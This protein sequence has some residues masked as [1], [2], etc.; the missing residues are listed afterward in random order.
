MAEKDDVLQSKHE[1]LIVEDSLTQ[2]QN[3]KHLLES[4]QYRVKVAGDGRHALAIIGE[5]K[6]DLVITD[7]VM[8]EM[9][10]YELCR[11]IKDG[12][13]TRDIPVILLTSLTNPE[14]VLEGLSC[15][16]DNFITKP[17]N[18]EYLLLHVGQILANRRLIP[19]ERIR[20]EVEIVFGGKRRFITADQQQMISLLLSTYEAAAQ[21]NA[22]LIKTQE[23]LE[24][25]ND[26]LEEIVEERTSELQSERDFAET[27]VK[28]APAA[29]LLLNLQGKIIH[30][31]PY[32]EE[33]S[34]Y[35]LEEVHGQNWFTDF[36]PESDQKRVTDMFALAIKG[37]QIIGNIHSVVCK[38]GSKRDFEW[39]NKAIKDKDGQITGLLAIGQDITEHRK[40]ELKI[41][42]LNQVLRMI[43]NVS[44]LIIREKNIDRLIQEV[45]DLMVKFSGYLGAW[46][47]L[48][49]SAGRFTQFGQAGL[50]KVIAE[51]RENLSRG[52]L[53]QC[54]QK[55]EID[56]G[57]LLVSD[58]AKH[59]QG[60][61]LM[62][63]NAECNCL[64]LKL[65]HDSKV[66]G[67]L[68]VVIDSSLGVDEE[69]LSLFTEMA[70]DVAFA[71]YSIDQT[72]EMAVGE[73]N[74]R[75]AQ[76]LAHIGNWILN[77]TTGEVWW[78]E[79]IHRIFG[80]DPA[81]PPPNIEEQRAIFMP[82]SW[83]RLQAAINQ[84]I[85][86]GTPY[87]LEVEYRRRDGTAGWGRA[88]GQA[89]HSDQGEV[90]ELHGAFQDITG[91]KQM[92]AELLAHQKNLEHL[93]AE[94]TG[95]LKESEERYRVVI[96][97][98]GQIVYELN[99]LTGQT[100][101]AGA[102]EE[103]LGYS[104]A[105]FQ[106][107]FEQRLARIHP[108]DQERIQPLMIAATKVPGAF[109]FEYRYLR[110]DDGFCFICD[111]GISLAD[112]EDQVFRV[113][114]TMADI[115]ERKQF[116]ETLERKTAELE[117]TKEAADRAN[118]A[119]SA[120][121]SN[122]SHE[123]RTPMN[124]ILGFSQL[125]ARDS[126]L[127]PTQ[128]GHV[129]TIIRSGNHLLT[130]IDDILDISKIEAGHATLNLST[131]SLQNLLADLK[132]MFNSR[133][134]SKGL[135][136]LAECDSNLPGYVLAD[137]NKLQQ[138]LINLLG[139]AFKFTSTGGV[140]VRLRN[141]LA[142][143]KPRPCMGPF[144]LV[145]EVEDTG[146]GID[147]EDISKI[148]N[149]FVQ[150][151]A[152]IKA[153]GTGL[154]LAI[155]RGFARLMSGD[156]TFTSQPGKGSCF[157]FNVLL[158]AVES[159]AELET[160]VSQQVVGLRPGT[161]PFRV[162]VADDVSENR[163]LIAE[164][165]SPVGF[166]VREAANGAEALEIFRDWS[167][168]IILMDLRMPI[169]NGYEAIKQ[170]RTTDAGRIIP[171]IALTASA[172]EDTQKQVMKIG[173]NTFL[174][175]PFQS[176]EL[177]AEIGKLLG[178][179][180]VFAD[181]PAESLTHSQ[182]VLI[183]PAALSVLPPDLLVKMQQAV[184]DGNMAGLMTLIEQVAEIDSATA[185][186]LRELADHFDYE[187]LVELFANAGKK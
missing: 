169:M 11:K 90:V 182:P 129:Q 114:G 157:R 43:R 187:K 13:G 77:P 58:R 73:K 81:L 102:I 34:G 80:H 178:L 101:H 125:L 92:E 4:G 149:T 176:E 111:R 75:S 146:P 184:M 82:A 122:M 78:S 133:A 96:E 47:I 40:D 151:G 164:L 135:Q 137:A 179:E 63:T 50:K 38:N 18:G 123:I 107:T 158:E 185:S 91:Q 21:R 94:R 113:I 56:H 88:L 172:F 108:D 22:E 42:H 85:R 186:G 160:L 2:A 9:N 171:I 93:V 48:T 29:I 181:K 31:N 162:L 16:A 155:S 20:I 5:H 112:S 53:P 61:F 27:L 168:H 109:K 24:I 14:D 69:E 45:C 15:G 110:K 62:D 98:T 87:D 99:V 119:K 104:T 30:F 120:F 166:E 159:V 106:L 51:A 131:F 52:I 118:R 174:R 70:G 161:G 39:H 35:R 71:L 8:P 46:I 89:V 19:V 148:F 12:A 150:A 66:F 64:R 140:S 79:E 10:G 37:A 17:F 173:V 67:Y 152:G 142:D 26:R 147:D 74:L 183:V 145:G 95:L 175:K 153:G 25:L 23:E 117:K 44:Q 139:N 141:D 126:S 136:F 163:E 1:I 7:I 124:A 65:S 28:T 132:M 41:Q 32:F 97:K 134:A 121:L 83:D 130:L 170:L 36:L 144:R 60:C 143:D 6:P 84:T 55:T 76:A 33:I 105:E 68:G 100:I 115:T 180:Y 177:F 103:L 127:K 138:I 49:D 154:G 116:E 156:I 57:L 86:S 72:K 128:A 3:L 165:L 59:C 167:P 54:C